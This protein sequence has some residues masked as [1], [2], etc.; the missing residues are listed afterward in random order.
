MFRLLINNEWI[1]KKDV[2]KFI[3]AYVCHRR[4]I[5]S[6]RATLFFVKGLYIGDELIKT[7]RDCS[8]P[9]VKDI[10]HYLLI[11]EDKDS[12]SKNDFESK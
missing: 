7:I 11:G 8:L 6:H 2:I 5:E 4:P 1:D 12:K 3:N 10:D 9:V